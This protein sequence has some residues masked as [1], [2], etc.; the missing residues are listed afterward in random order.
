MAISVYINPASATA[1][2]YDEIIRRLEAAG[3]GE[4]AGRL[5]HACFGSGDKLQ[6]FDIWESQQAFDK[7]AETMVPIVQEVGLDL[8]QPMVDPVHNLIQG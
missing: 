8:G 3:A 2:Q 1:A 5:Y 6:V 4:P 7:F